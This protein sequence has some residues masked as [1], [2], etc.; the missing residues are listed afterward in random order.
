MSYY[1]LILVLSISVPFLFSF[2]NKIL[3]YKNFLFLLKSILLSSIPFI[4]WDFIFTDLGVWG[5]NKNF[6]S[7]IYIYNLPIEEV[8]FFFFIPFCCLFTYHVINKYKMSFF[9]KYNFVY[10]NFFIVLFLITALITNQFKL[11]TFICVVNCI[12]LL[13]IEN[14]YL[15]IIDYDLFYTLFLLIFIPFVIVD[16]A[17]TGLFFDQTIVWYNNE[18]ILGIHILTIPIEDLVYSHQLILL[19]LIIYKMFSTNLKKY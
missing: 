3:F 9:K 6:V 19:N 2:H 15:K 8:L 7:N 16:G 14:L 10:I 17:L 4:F 13:L 12:L 1:Y 11:Y 5:F 18:D